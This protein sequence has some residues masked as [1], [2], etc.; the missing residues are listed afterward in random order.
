MKKHLWKAFSLYPILT[1]ATTGI[2]AKAAP[3]DY[4][5]F[6]KTLN[7]NSARNGFND[8][9]AASSN[10]KYTAAVP[11]VELQAAVKSFVEDYIEKNDEM[12]DEI[13]SKAIHVLQRL[14]KYFKSK[15]SLLS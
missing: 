8:T 14:K 4:N 3:P 2:T 7:L 5:R 12:L 15:V 10:K 6:K 11:D 9:L 13:N 1:F